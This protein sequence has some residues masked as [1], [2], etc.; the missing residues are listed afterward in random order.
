MVGTKKFNPLEKDPIST[1]RPILV[2]LRYRESLS[3]PPSFL[4]SLWEAELECAPASNGTDSSALIA[5][6]RSLS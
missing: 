1:L 4:G 2:A 5:I 3:L 6:S